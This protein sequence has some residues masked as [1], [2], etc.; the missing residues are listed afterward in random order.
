MQRAVYPGTFDPMTMGH[1]D[2]VKRA[3]KLFDSVIIAIAS[4]DSKKPMFS[5]EERIEIGNKIF[6]DDPKVEVVGFSGLLV[7]F[8]KENDA[9]ILIRGLRVVADFE[10]EF[11]LANMNRAMSPDIE[12]VFLTPKEE[13]SYI[14]SSLV[15][16]IATMGGDVTR[17]VD[18]VTLEALNQKIKN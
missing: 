14:S 1:V 10:Y 15:K 13:Y 12:S 9:N 16:E 6:A 8:A 17:F 11:Q 18:P 4:S 5:L 2:L 3:S 7:N